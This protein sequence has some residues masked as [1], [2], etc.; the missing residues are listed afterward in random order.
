MAIQPYLG[1][2]LLA[3]GIIR[4]FGRE[5]EGLTL[6]VQGLGI[7]PTSNNPIVLQEQIDGLTQRLDVL[8]PPGAAGAAAPPAAPPPP[9]PGDDPIALQQ[10]IDRLTRR[11][12]A[13]GPPRGPDD[14]PGDD[15][16]RQ[17]QDGIARLARIYGFSYLGNYYKIANPPVLRVFGQG[18]HVR[19]GLAPENHMDILGVE[20]KDE[21]FVRGIRMWAVDQL[22][23]VV[24]IDITIGWLRELLLDND[25]SPETNVTGNG[26]GGR[27]DVVGRDSGLVGRDSGL[28]GR[29]SGFVGRSRR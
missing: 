6:G 14:D 16:D 12:R 7:D 21:D 9:D 10:Q 17:P 18:F 11:L 25:M 28:V 2:G 19:P 20:F 3:P 24:R 15:P 1:E 27:A 29:D 26:S 13:L 8:D 4:L 5:F 23:V 22:D